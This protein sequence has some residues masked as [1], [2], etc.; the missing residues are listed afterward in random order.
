MSVTDLHRQGSLQPQR[1]VT[2]RQSVINKA[3]AD[4]WDEYFSA[5][6]FGKTLFE[7]IVLTELN[8]NL[9]CIYFK[10]YGYRVKSRNH[11]RK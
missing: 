1:N 11:G 7:R 2:A 4:A 6:S 10:H 8:S 9:F 5:R 3:L